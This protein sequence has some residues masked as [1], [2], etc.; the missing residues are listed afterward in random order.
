[1]ALNSRPDD[2]PKLDPA[3]LPAE[4]FSN[5]ISIACRP[6]TYTHAHMFPLALASINRSWRSFILDSP[7]IWASLCVDL[8]YPVPMHGFQMF[9]ERSRSFQLDIVLYNSETVGLSGEPPEPEAPLVATL[10]QALNSQIGRWRSLKLFPSSEN[11]LCIAISNFGGVAES[12]EDLVIGNNGAARWLIRETRWATKMHGLTSLK[13][14]GT[15]VDITADD[16]STFL[17]NLSVESTLEVLE[18][19][20]RP[21]DVIMSGSWD[22]VN[23][24]TSKLR[25]PRL[26]EIRF[27]GCSPALVDEICTFYMEA[28]NLEIVDILARPGC[29]I[30]GGEEY[31]MSMS[32]PF[33]PGASSII[34]PFPKLRTFRFTGSYRIGAYMAPIESCE[35]LVVSAVCDIAETLDRLGT[36]H[37]NVS[38]MGDP[39]LVWWGEDGPPPPVEGCQL[40]NVLAARQG[41]AGLGSLVNAVTS[42]IVYD[43][44]EL[45]SDDRVWFETNLATF[46]W[47]RSD[48][49][50]S[51]DPWDE[52]TWG[53]CY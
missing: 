50:A 37:D 52:V 41:A 45:S 21:I 8:S 53:R 33:H 11:A 35:H 40:R 25:L 14:T 30:S 18:F 47:V 43:E 5:I 32:E 38:C 29:I 1:M 42:L 17:R 9:L 20:G 36:F 51:P 7:S 19:S 13:L 22:P 39:S 23:P 24:P 49:P 44:Q 15:D 46:M 31:F 27:A 4:I 48:R 28:P 6:G 10:V 2:K 34:G 16:F 26:K 3:Y 12:L